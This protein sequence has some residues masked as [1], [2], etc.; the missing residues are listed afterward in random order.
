MCGIAGLV[1]D[2]I[3]GLM[4]RMNAAQRH[5]GPDGS[6]LIEDQEAEAALGHVRLAILDLSD[7]SAQPMVSHDGRYVIVFN[8]EIYNFREL[9]SELENGGPPFVSTGDTEVLLRG[10]ARQGERFLERLNGMFA[11]ALWDRRERELLLAR[12]QLGIKPL[13]Y[14]EPVP[15]TLLF[16]SEIKALC[17]HPELRREPDF[18]AIQQHLTFCHA[19]GDRTAMKGVRRLPPATLLRWST[20][21]RRCELKRYWSPTY[22]AFDEPQTSRTKAVELLRE[23]VVDSTRRQLVSDVPVGSFLSGGLDSSLV[24]AAALQQDHAGFACYTISVPQEANALDQMGEDAPYARRLA[25]QWKVPL[26]EL[27]IGSDA[28]SLYPDLIHFLDEPIADPAVINCYLRSRLAREHGTKVLLSGPGADELFAGYP[29][30]AAL[31]AL[32]HADRLPQAMRRVVARAAGLLPGARSG[33]AGALVRR[34]RRVLIELENDPA[35]QFLS[36]CAA[37]AA[38]EITSLFSTDLREQLP[39]GDGTSECRH[40]MEERGFPGVEACLDRDLSIY[41]PNHNLLY[42]D[43]MGMAVG[44]E[45]RVPLLDME[46]VP[47]ATSFPVPWK[48]GATTKAILRDA[49]RGLIPNEVI[50]RPKAGFG[51][52]YRHWLRHDLVDLWSDI[53]SEAAVRRRGWF[54]PRALRS[55]RDRSQSGEADL[56]MLQWSV[57]TVELWARRFLDENPAISQAGNSE[58]EPNVVRIPAAA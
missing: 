43:K 45:T 51:A 48:L 38:N 39:S 33:R 5:R 28:T 53:S 3:P 54:D 13:Y 11:F 27:P 29:R 17:A 21:R 52:P 30:Y 12:D 55:A 35:Q 58:A 8:G 24:T 18:V 6:G 25:R 4:T 49:A 44:V 9:R 2:F 46:L 15:G 32:R 22:G 14:A 26:H 40:F 36:W 42:T 20:R 57:L 47:L 1:G 50:D 10:L 16:A 19:G 34:A 31:H 37:T 23:R 7:R 41:L 56:Y